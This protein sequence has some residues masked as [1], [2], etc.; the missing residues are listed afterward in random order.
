M[1]VTIAYIIGAVLAFIA[2]VLACVLVMPKKRLQ[3]FKE[4]KFLVWLHNIINFKSLLIEKI[5]KVLYVFF[6]AACVF[7]GFFMLFSKMGYRTS[8]APMGLLVMILGPVLVRLIFEASML[9]VINTKN[10]VEINNKMGD[11]KGDDPEIL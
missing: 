8:A 6:T 11:G 3:E 2:T 9:F 10:V 4:N 1:S 7:T 5:L